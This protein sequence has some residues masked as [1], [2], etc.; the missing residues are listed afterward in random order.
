MFRYPADR[1]QFLR[2]LEMQIY[3]SRS[4]CLNIYKGKRLVMQ[5]E[6]GIKSNMLRF[7]A[8]VGKF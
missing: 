3:M 7:P 1:G 6:F 2:H 8:D 5:H 4:F